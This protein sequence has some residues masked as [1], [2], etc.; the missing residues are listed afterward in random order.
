MEQKQREHNISA[1]EWFDSI[2]TALAVVMV[3]LV[4]FLRTSRVDGRSMN[5]T[6]QSGDQVIA[7]SLFYKPDR[8]DIVIIDSETNFGQPLV[9]RVIGIAGD[10]IDINFQTGEVFLNGVLLEEDYI[11]APT[12]LSFDVQFPVTV[13]EGHLFLMG[14]NRPNSEDSRSSLIGMID[15]RDVLGKVI[16]RIYPFSEFGGI[17]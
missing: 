11:S 5:P 16:F 12:N 15:E 17:E 9:K 4:F 14:D 10:T 2:V 6:L 1:L 8:G 7:R 3:I 13:P